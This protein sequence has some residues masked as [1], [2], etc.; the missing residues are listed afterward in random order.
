MHTEKVDA[1]NRGWFAMWAET[2]RI[3]QQTAITAMS[4]WWLRRSGTDEIG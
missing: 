3:Q 2:A 1:F 4:T